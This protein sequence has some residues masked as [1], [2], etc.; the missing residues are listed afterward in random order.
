LRHLFLDQVIDDDLRTVE[1]IACRHGSASP[2]LL[3]GL[4]AC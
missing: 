4:D 2:V 1:R 3:L